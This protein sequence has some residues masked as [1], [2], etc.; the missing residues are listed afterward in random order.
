MAEKSRNMWEVYHT[1][2]I[3]VSNHSA[4]FLYTYMYIYGG[5]FYIYL[6]TKQW[7]WCDVVQLKFHWQLFFM[8]EGHPW[9]V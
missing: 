9:I 6:C 1:L 2:F 3:T 5:Q 8:T 7:R 4:D